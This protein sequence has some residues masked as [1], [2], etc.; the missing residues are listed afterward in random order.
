MNET[1]CR[2]CKH[3]GIGCHDYC[4]LYAKYARGKERE[5]QERQKQAKLEAWARRLGR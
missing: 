4:L 1:P 2:N 5:R 3:R